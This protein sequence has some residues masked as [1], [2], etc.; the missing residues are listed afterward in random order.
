MFAPYA[1]A[2]KMT[3]MRIKHHRSNHSD[4][5]HP[6]VDPNN[7]ENTSNMVESQN[8]SLKTAQLYPQRGVHRKTLP[9]HLKEWEFHKRFPENQSMA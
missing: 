6:F 4:P 1:I 8:S 9:S 7:P 2:T 5:D 3:N